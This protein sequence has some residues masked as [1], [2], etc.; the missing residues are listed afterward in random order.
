[1]SFVAISRVYL[2]SD[3]TPV[4]SGKVTSVL[5]NVCSL[6]NGTKKGR[7]W[8]VKISDANPR[9]FM[10]RVLKIQDC[11]WDVEE[12]LLQMNIA[13]NEVKE[14]I[15]IDSNLG[16]EKDLEYCAIISKSLASVLSGYLSE[17]KIVS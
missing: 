8:N 2:T 17:A 13:M 5:H 1:M 10:I 14:V 11:L 9:G 7:L 12:E 16:E 4:L 6:V 15:Q 3:F